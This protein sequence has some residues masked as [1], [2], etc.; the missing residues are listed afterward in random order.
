MDVCSSSLNSSSRAGSDAARFEEPDR[1][2]KKDTDLQ[3]RVVVE[4]VKIST[5][6]PPPT[7]FAPFGSTEAVRRLPEQSQLLA[8]LRNRF[9]HDELVAAGAAFRAEAGDL[10]IA[11]VLN[12]ESACF[13]LAD[14]T[15]APVD[16]V[17]RCGSLSDNMHWQK[18]AA[19]SSTEIYRFEVPVVLCE[20]DAELFVLSRFGIK[21]LPIGGLSRR[22]GRERVA[23]RSKY[24]QNR[25]FQLVVPA[26]RIDSLLIDPSAS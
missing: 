22:D 7:K 1:R 8:R 17:S 21:C 6:A 26:W 12:T 5:A 9:T 18:L 2:A 24:R 25:E 14:E 10:Q 15:G 11:P 4:I 16:L 13:V 23:R 20:S 3:K 19:A